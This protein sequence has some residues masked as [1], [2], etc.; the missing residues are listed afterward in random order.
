M[1]DKTYSIQGNEFIMLPLNLGLMN[2][3]APLL[4]KYRKLHFEYTGDIDMK[5]VEEAE[6][7][8]SDLKTV[9]DEL[10]DKE[11][12]NSGRIVE[13]KE[14]LQ[15]LEEQFENNRKLQSLISFY[16]DCEGLAMYRL[17][18][19]GNIIK[20]FLKNVLAPAGNCSTAKI[21]NVDFNLAGAP[22][23]IK[24]V[25]TDFFTLTLQNAEK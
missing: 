14:K 18:T 4:L 5:Q 19:D 24:E 1:N 10:E 16:N 2:K 23:F 20:P 21:E 25:L 15:M 6:E 11:G 13:Q 8:I 17:L 9:I 22:E 3:A 12:D 7:K